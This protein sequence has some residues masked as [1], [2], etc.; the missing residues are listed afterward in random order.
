MA[1]VTVPQ[2][3][4]QRANR[5]DLSD[6]Y[7]MNPD[8]RIPVRINLRR[9]PTTALCQATDVLAITDRSIQDTR[10]NKDCV[11]NDGQVVKEIHWWDG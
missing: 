7:S 5:K 6:R 4:N 2:R 3:G 11:E 8:R 9:E 1:R 10:R